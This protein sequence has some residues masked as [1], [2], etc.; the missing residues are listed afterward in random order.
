MYTRQEL[1][2]PAGAG[3]T[4]G[5]AKRCFECKGKELLRDQGS[6]IQ[7]GPGDMRIEKAQGQRERVEK[8]VTCYKFTVTSLQ[9]SCTYI[10]GSIYS[11]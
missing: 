7:N 10:P 6:K 8:G 4:S 2:D 3:K 9:H 5:A 11:V 1:R